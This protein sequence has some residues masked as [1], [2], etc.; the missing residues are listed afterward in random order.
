MANSS[1][2]IWKSLKYETIYRLNNF[3]AIKITLKYYPEMG[4]RGWLFAANSNGIKK[5]FYKEEGILYAHKL[6]AY[7]KYGK[8]L[9][10]DFPTFIDIEDEVILKKIGYLE[11]VKFNRL[12]MLDLD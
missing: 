11:L 9:A 5:G 3:D 2:V 7:D 10:R 8:P 4:K 6:N 1:W 12:D